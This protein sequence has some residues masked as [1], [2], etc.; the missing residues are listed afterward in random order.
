MQ[1]KLLCVL[2]HIW[3]KGEVGAPWNR[4][5]LSSKTFLLTVPRQ[6]F[7]YGY[8]VL[9]LSCISQAFASVHCC[10][11]VTWR[12]RANLLALV[13][14]VYCN[15]VTFPFGFLGKVW[16]L[17]VL[18]PDPCYLS[19]FVNGIF[20]NIHG[21]MHN[22]VSMIILPL[23]VS[24]TFITSSNCFLCQ[25]NHFM[26]I[27]KVLSNG[28]LLWRFFVVFFSFMG[29][30]MIQKQRLVG[31]HLPASKTPFKWRFAGVSKMAQYWLLAWELYDFKGIR[32]SI[33]KNTIFLW[34][35]RG[36]PTPCPP[37]PPS[38]SAHA[39]QFSLWYRLKSSSDVILDHKRECPCSQVFLYR[40]EGSKMWLLNTMLI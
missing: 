5:K 18:I 23:N 39:L 17:I 27:Q 1:T 26:R 14:D 7:F 19:S 40:T 37:P 36:V 12:D 11:V 32:T 15:F 16:Y 22:P 30:G 13:C 8:Y 4:F 29:G 38:G 21:N 28:V 35:S 6:Y 24:K 20:V 34:F 33:A 2:I 10:L 3:T 9:F 25:N 31:H